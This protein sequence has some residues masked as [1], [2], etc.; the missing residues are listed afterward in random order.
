LLSKIANGSSY[1]GQ[2]IEGLFDGIGKW[3]GPEGEAYDGIFAQGLFK[4]EETFIDG[5][6]HGE[7]KLIIMADGTVETA[8]TVGK[9][10]CQECGILNPPQAKF[11][12]EC[13]KKIDWQ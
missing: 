3:S 10:I 11:C 6:K 13:G 4:G 2:W 8:S 12:S 7:A 5:K 9:N 1:V